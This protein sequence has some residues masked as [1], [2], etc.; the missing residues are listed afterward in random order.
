MEAKVGKVAHSAFISFNAYRTLQN[1]YILY[2]YNT[3]SAEI[4][5]NNITETNY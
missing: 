2:L 5:E 3:I 4:I 1:I